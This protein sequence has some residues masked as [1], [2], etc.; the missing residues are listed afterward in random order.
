MGFDGVQ[1]NRRF[2]R[3]SFVES[4]HWMVLHRPVELAAAS[5][6]VGPSTEMS[7]NATHA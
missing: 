3:A 5:G 6:E 1:L 7:D 2:S 4:M